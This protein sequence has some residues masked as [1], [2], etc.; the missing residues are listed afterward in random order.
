MEWRGDRV[1]EN[2]QKAIRDSTAGPNEVALIQKAIVHRDARIVW[3]KRAEWSRSDR[4]AT[5][6]IP[7]KED[8]GASSSAVAVQDKQVRF[9]V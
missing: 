5:G 2:W 8:Q 6:L 1:L 9:A 7:P 4:L 3:K